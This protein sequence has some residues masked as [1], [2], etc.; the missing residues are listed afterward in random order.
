MPSHVDI[1]ENEAADAYASA[2]DH[3]EAPALF[4]RHFVEAKRLLKAVVLQRYPD[5]QVARGAPRIRNE[6][7]SE[8]S[9]HYC[10]ALELAAL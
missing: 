2:A 6:L 5:E 7:S 4:L 9:V 1:L 3:H 10:T 8:L